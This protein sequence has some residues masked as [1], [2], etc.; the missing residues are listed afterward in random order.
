MQSQCP[1]VVLAAPVNTVADLELPPVVDPEH[2][3]ELVHSRPWFHTMDLGHGIVTPG[4][5][6]S[7]EKLP[8]IGLP[9][10]L[11]GRSV[12]DVGTFD[13]FFAFEA[14]RRGAAR[15]VAADDFCWSRPDDALL[16]GKGFDIARW[17]LESSVEKVRV[18]VEDLGP[19]LVGGR[20]DYVLFL[21]VLYHAQD[22]L[23]YLRNVFSVCGGTLIVETHVDAL[24]QNRPMMVFY[25]GG[26]LNGDPSNFWGPNLACVQAMLLE[27]GFSQVEMVSRVGSRAT[28]HAHR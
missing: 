5:D 20:F 3:R 19:E 12:L 27:V 8:L 21:G 23:R 25:P 24:D 16:D 1:I 14:E 7:P 13:G 11:R 4:V 18:S 22:P 6:A 9:E 15:V 2:L 28:F 17:G 26:A 10:N